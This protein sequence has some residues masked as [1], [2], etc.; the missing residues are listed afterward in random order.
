MP[1]LFTRL[2]PTL[3]LLMLMSHTPTSMELL[4]TTQRLTS[5][6]LRLPMPTVLFL[7]LM[8]LL[9]PMAVPSTSNTPQTTTTDML[10]MSHMKVLQ[11]TLKML[12]M[13]LPLPQPTMPKPSLC[14][15]NIYQ[16]LLKIYTI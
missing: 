6:L 12:L 13:L 10:L 16:Y 15:I 14:F 9:F 5:M 4:M 2:L 11:P 3:N 7:D 8:M 1:Q